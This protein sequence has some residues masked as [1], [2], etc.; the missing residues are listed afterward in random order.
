MKF[1]NCD[2]AN[3]HQNLTKFWCLKVL[4]FPGLFYWKNT[5]RYHYWWPSCCCLSLVTPIKALG[6]VEFNKGA[7]NYYL[8][9]KL[10][11]T[12]SDENIVP[13]FDSTHVKGKFDLKK[14]IQ[15]W[16]EKNSIFQL[17]GIDFFYALAQ[18]SNIGQQHQLARVRTL[19]SVT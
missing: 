6:W 13:Q 18:W 12:P 3:A 8:W 17:S 5:R 10:K 2:P 4:N 1:A 14:K 11:V 19:T 9:I 15:S 7:G 16:K